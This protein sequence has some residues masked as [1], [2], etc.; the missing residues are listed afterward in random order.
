MI[1][2]PDGQLFTINCFGDIICFDL[3]EPIK[4]FHLGFYQSELF[5]STVSLIDPATSSDN[6]LYQT[7]QAAFELTLDASFQTDDPNSV[8]TNN[9]AHCNNTSCAVFISAITNKICILQTDVILPYSKAKPSQSQFRYK[10]E[11]IFSKRCLNPRLSQALEPIKSNTN[12]M[13]EI[14]HDILYSNN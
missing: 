2:T 1:A 14:I 10:C 4:A 11:N 3:G 6:D 7:N 13:S 8:N 5:T 12:L 9:N